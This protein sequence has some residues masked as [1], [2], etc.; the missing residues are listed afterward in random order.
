[1][2]ETE[3]GLTSDLVPLARRSKVM[4]QENSS[5]QSLVDYTLRTAPL[6]VVYFSVAASQSS[7]LSP[8]HSPPLD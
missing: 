7:F 3:R 1:M 2:A 4:E 8:S 5:D 6:R